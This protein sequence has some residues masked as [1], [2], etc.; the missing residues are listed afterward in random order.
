MKPNVATT[1]SSV[2]PLP[3]DSAAFEGRSVR[4][5]ILIVDDTAD[6]LFVLGELLRPFYRV[7]VANSGARALAVAASLPRP[8][9]ILLDVMMP[10]MDGFECLTQLRE[11][12][13][14]R[15]I[16]VIF[17][18]AL[19]SP[20]DEERGLELGAAD[21]IPKPLWPAVVLARVNTQLELRR[22]RDQLRDQNAFLQEQL[23]RF[24][25][26]LAHHLQEPVRLQYLYGQMLERDLPKPLPDEAQHSLHT[27]IRGAERLRRLIKDIQRFVA[28]HEAA[29]VHA[30]CSAEQVFDQAREAMDARAEA[31]GARIERG[32]LPPVWIGTARLFA[33]F[34][35]LLT[36]AID[37]RS[38][39][40]P[41]V[42]R[43]SAAALDEETVFSLTDN[44]RGIAPAYRDRVFALF[45]RLAHDGQ[46]EGSGL[47]LALVRK[48]VEDGGGRAWI[49]AGEDGGVSV[50]FTLPVQA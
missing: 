27:V 29:P 4:S 28:L 38:P 13:V 33:I 44:G 20:E 15:D 43:A 40:R 18:T 8:D 41:L 48:I 14:T 31:V 23:R 2:A 11:A 17:L 6:T 36:N 1:K 5:T 12:A 19:S 39:D 49:T 9:L 37:F 7:R 26:I 35:A 34:E 46:A 45:E 22:A 42:V 47:G 24:M 25:E 50:K 10:E 3:V 16:P 32:D 21:Y 30:L